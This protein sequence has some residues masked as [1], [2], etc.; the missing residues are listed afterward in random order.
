MGLSP[1]AYEPV[2]ITPMVVSPSR[3]DVMNS[4]TRMAALGKSM[5]SSSMDDIRRARLNI[6]SG[7]IKES[8]ESPGNAGIGGSHGQ[9]GH[10]VRI[11]T[12]DQVHKDKMQWRQNTVEAVAAQLATL[13]GMSV[14][15]GVEL[16]DEWKEAAT[17]DGRM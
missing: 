1:A 9:E 15:R 8:F 5:T 16:G 2:R 3:R 6:V 12:G 7:N 17:A 11:G 13:G 14:E 4:T 10:L